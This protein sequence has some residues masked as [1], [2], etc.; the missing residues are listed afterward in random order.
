MIGFR[1]VTAT[2][3]LSALLIAPAI[4]RAADEQLQEEQLAPPATMETQPLTPPV[5]IEIPAPAPTPPAAVQWNQLEAARRDARD[6]AQALR[7]Q[8]ILNESQADLAQ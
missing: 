6:R 4:A 5:T 7:A 8:S 2:A 1:A 3:L